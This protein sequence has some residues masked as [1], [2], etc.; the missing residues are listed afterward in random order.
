M[1]EDR[2]KTL[3]LCFEEMEEIARLHDDLEY[4]LN[5]V[6]VKLCS[7]LAHLY[8]S[9]YHHDEILRY[10]GHEPEIELN[11]G[12]IPLTKGDVSMIRSSYYDAISET[13]ET[14]LPYFK[15][16]K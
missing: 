10:L 2:S 7:M 9:D 5:E 1:T 11:E 15:T 3:K 14:L 6:K 13:E 16:K 8:V 4:C 12:E